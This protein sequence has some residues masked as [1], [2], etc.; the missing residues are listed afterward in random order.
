MQ[1]NIWK[2]YS[3]TKALPSTSFSK[4]EIA[5]MIVATLFVLLVL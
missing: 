3:D 5:V 2:N 4:K 1:N